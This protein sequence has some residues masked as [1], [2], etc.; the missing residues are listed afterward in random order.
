MDALLEEHKSLNQKMRE[1][2]RACG[3]GHDGASLDKHVT[4]LHR[5]LA[6]HFEAEEASPLYTTL[7]NDQPVYREALENL[8]DKHPAILDHCARLMET[9]QDLMKELA[10]LIETIRRHEQAEAEIIQKVYVRDT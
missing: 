9:S 1:L 2:E 8:R 5:M 6:A 4:E 10:G 3:L 7:P